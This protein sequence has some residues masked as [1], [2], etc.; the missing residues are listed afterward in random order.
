MGCVQLRTPRYV[1]YDT[2]GHIPDRT[3]PYRGVPNCKQPR[4]ELNNNYTEITDL[5]GALCEPSSRTLILRRIGA[6]RRA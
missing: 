4:A 6:L 1:S 3:E 2:P 5:G